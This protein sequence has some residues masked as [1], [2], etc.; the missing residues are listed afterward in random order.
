MNVSLPQDLLQAD[1][2]MAGKH[3]YGDLYNQIGEDYNF[4]LFWA[5]KPPTKAIKIL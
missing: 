3:G 2:H 4:S 1:F 5:Y